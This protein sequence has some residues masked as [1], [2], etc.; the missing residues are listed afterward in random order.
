MHR[1]QSL[2][3]TCT[4]QSRVNRAGHP[5]ICAGPACGSR[6]QWR[7]CMAGCEV[8]G[9]RVG[10]EGVLRARRREAA[11]QCVSSLL[12]PKSRS[13]TSARRQW[14]FGCMRRRVSTRYGGRGREREE[15][16]GQEKGETYHVCNSLHHLLRA[17][18]WAI[19]FPVSY[20]TRIWDV[21]P[22]VPV[23]C[24]N[25]VQLDFHATLHKRDARRPIQMMSI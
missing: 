14:A 5:I 11:P 21:R 20:F 18:R 13:D 3:S 12:L 1:A 22:R 24:L 10:R 6:R 25:L 4:A 7:A 9:C 17:V 8:R 2:V 15:E 16:E 19:V 23:L